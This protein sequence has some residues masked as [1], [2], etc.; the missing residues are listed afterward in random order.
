MHDSAQA[1]SLS[2][3]PPESPGSFQR[4]CKH[5]S[6]LNVAM[7]VRQ[8]SSKSGGAQPISCQHRKLAHL[9]PACHMLDFRLQQ[10]AKH[11]VEADTDGQVEVCCAS[12]STKV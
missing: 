1:P 4:C 12:I 7:R 5:A 11:C 8:S 2:E 10:G 6:V 9:M 3:S